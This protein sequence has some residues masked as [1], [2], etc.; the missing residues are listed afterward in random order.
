MSQRRIGKRIKQVISYYTFIL[1]V[2]HIFLILAVMT[3]T[4][5]DY[6]NQVPSR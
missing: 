4:Q 1:F 2:A 5:F 3:P 6:F